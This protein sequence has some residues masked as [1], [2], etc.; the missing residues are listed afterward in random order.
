MIRVANAFGGWVADVAQ[1]PAAWRSCPH[2]PDWP[3]MPLTYGPLTFFR[4]N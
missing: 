1:A 2:W 3:S 4:Q